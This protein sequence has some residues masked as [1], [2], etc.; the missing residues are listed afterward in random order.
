MTKN[1]LDHTRRR[2]ERIMQAKIDE[3][4]KQNGESEHAFLMAAAE[5]AIKAP[6]LF[7]T[8][9]VEMLR[10]SHCTYITQVLEELPGFKAK[11]KQWKARLE[12]GN[13]KLRRLIDALDEEKDRIMDVLCLAG[14][15]RDAMMMIAEFKR[16]SP[17]V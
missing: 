14:G 3:F 16:F 5:E 8:R 6:K 1:Q 13:N 7:A 15:S 10:R 17:K 11:K 4:K 12:A 9:A 2:L